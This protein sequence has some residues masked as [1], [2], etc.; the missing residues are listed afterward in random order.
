LSTQLSLSLS[1]IQ[2][3]VLNHSLSKRYLGRKYA[4]E[5]ILVGV[6]VA[7][8]LLTTLRIQVLLDLLLASRHLSTLP[9]TTITN[10]T[11]SNSNHSQTNSLVH[12]TSIILDTLLCILVDSPVALR[13][14]EETNGPQAV[15]KI[16]KR[17]G[18][19]RQ[20]R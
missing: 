19:P 7:C 16:L 3:V 15:V 8:G 13:V 9:L 5:V 12:L 11:P 17:A 14:F 2:G 4:L 20:V 6:L 10:I 18:T 1:V